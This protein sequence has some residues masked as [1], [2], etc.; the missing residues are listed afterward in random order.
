MQGHVVAEQQEK[1]LPQH[2]LDQLP[3]QAP[4]QPDQPDEAGPL[5]VNWQEESGRDNVTIEGICS[6]ALSAD[7]SAP[8]K[9]VGYTLQ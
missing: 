5:T 7:K 6:Q 8:C 9:C 4:P 3:P 2:Y 1:L